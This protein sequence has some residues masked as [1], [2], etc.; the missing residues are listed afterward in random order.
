MVCMGCFFPGFQGIAGLMHQG[1]EHH[2]ESLREAGA[3]IPPDLVRMKTREE[4]PG[5]IAQEEEGMPVKQ[6]SPALYCQ[7]G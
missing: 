2:I 3:Q 7:H 1:G 5:G 4:K 6:E